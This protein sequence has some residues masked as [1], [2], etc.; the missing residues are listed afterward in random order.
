[1]FCSTPNFPSYCQEH[2]AHIRPC[3]QL[4]SGKIYIYIFYFLKAFLSFN[5]DDYVNDLPELP[6][7]YSAEYYVDNTKLF[8]SFNL[9]DSQQIV[10]EMKKVLLHVRDS[11]RG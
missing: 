2:S 7:H 3:V 10:Q 4:K 5:R 6:R 1:M 9:H 11:R 8:V